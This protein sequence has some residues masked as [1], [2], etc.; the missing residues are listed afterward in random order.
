M[1]VS[2]VLSLAAVIHSVGAI[3]TPSHGATKDEKGAS[4]AEQ[5][6]KM[7]AE[8]FR[9]LN[10]FAVR[11]TEATSTRI[12]GKSR[13][14]EAVYEFAAAR[15]N[16]VSCRVKGGGPL[17][18]SVVCDGQKLYSLLPGRKRHTETAAPAQAWQAL[19]PTTPAL[20]LLRSLLHSDPYR[21]MMVGVQKVKYVGVEQA[22]GARSHHIKLSRG[23][24]DWD[25]WLEDG[26]PPLPRK[27]ESRMSSLPGLRD[28]KQGFLLHRVATFEKWTLDPELPD[29]IFA[30]TAP[31]NSQKAH[32]LFG[33]L[34]ERHSSLGKPAPGFRLPQVGG[35]IVE[36]AT[37]KGKHVVVLCFCAESGKAREGQLA[38]LAAVAKDYSPKGV[39]FYAIPLLA[40]PQ[41]AEQPAAGDAPPYALLLDRE[42]AVSKQYG[43]TQAPHV[44][45]IGRNG[46]V[47]AV[48]LGLRPHQ[49]A[50]LREELDALFGGKSL[51]GRADEDR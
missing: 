8:Y 45:V 14:E 32:T 50:T 2:V 41:S 40:D 20:T 46:V 49:Q 19:R 47:E 51:A 43:V 26:E 9:G 7:L 44:T 31:T 23:P 38:V 48:H 34:I 12:G 21:V 25:L 29:E 17:A 4:N 5:R 28:A 35:G 3:G 22:G 15:P 33:R 10:S 11:I 36:L 13:D 6:L 27:L 18:V 39:I 30:A 1:K 24:E 42:G 16:R 37:H